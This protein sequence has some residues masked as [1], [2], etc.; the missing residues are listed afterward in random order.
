MDERRRFRDDDGK[1]KRDHRRG[2]TGSKDMTSHSMRPGF[3]AAERRNAEVLIDLA[4]AED[5]GQSGDLTAT[6]TIPSQARGA[7]R[8]VTRA[9][10][11]VAGLP[12]VAILAGRFELGDFWQTLVDDGDRVPPGTAIARVAGS[13]RSLL[14]LERTALN[15]LQRLGGF[16]TLTARFVAQ[17]AGTRAVILDTRAGEVCGPPRRRPE[18]PDRAL[19]RDPDQGQPPRLA[20][21]RGRPHRLGAGGGPGACAPGGVRRSRGSADDVRLRGARPAAR[22]ARTSLVA[23]G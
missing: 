6:V 12:V 9:D 4:L 10:G 3:G 18:S 15:F 17:V 22:L 2:R 5:L 13:M 11:V 20:R 1:M 14:A 19:R 8:F 23:L 7:A 16:A 21:R